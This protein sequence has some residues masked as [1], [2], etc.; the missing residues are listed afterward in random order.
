[1]I[2]TLLLAALLICPAIAL[3]Q[4]TPPAQAAAKPAAA[5]P[6]ATKIVSGVCAACH[7]ADGHG[8]APT[9]PN[10]AGLPAD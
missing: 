8:T 3:A 5:A 7:G 2:R 4:S 9:N 10:L 6:D 1:M